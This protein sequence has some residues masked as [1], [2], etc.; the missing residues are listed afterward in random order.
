[1]PAPTPTKSVGK[2]GLSYTTANNTN[3]FSLSGQ[4]SKVS[5]SYDWFYQPCDISVS[6]YTYSGTA[7][8]H[9]P[10]IEFI[11]LLYSDAP[12]LLT[13]WP[14]AAT[15]AIAGGATALM[16][17]NEPVGFLRVSIP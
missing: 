12:D 10:A 2:R 4:N 1:M 6:N 13:Y 7:C 15:R 9:N 5:W 16:S 17:F 14:G 3:F 11:P 8:F